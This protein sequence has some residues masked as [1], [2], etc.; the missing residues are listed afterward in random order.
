[1]LAREGE[2]HWKTWAGADLVPV[3]SGAGKNF[4]WLMADNRLK[5]NEIRRRTNIATD[6]A[7]M[8]CGAANRS[9]ITSVYLC[10]GCVGDFKG[11][12]GSLRFLCV[13]VS[14]VA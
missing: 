4:I 11:G 9:Y 5:T 8:V 13:T 14:I 1:M 6:A 3:L 12:L 2:G 10:Q 7:C